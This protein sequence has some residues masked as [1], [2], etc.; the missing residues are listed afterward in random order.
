VVRKLARTRYLSR[1]NF[2]SAHI[3]RRSSLIPWWTV[4][5]ERQSGKPI[6]IPEVCNLGL[7]GHVP[8]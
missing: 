6:K 3:G 7:Q 5:V 1:S 8:Q 2:A 4:I